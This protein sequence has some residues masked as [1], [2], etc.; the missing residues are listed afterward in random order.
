[1]KAKW[2]Y[3]FWGGMDLFYVGRFCYVNF[4][5]GRIPFYTDIQ[6]YALVGWGHGSIPGLFFLLDMALNISIIF[7]M[8][9]FFRGSRIAPYVAYAQAPFRLLLAIPS[10][11]F[12]IWFT[13]VGE[14]TSV[15]LLVSLL[16]VSELAKVFSIFFREKVS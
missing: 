1:M 7:S 11:S 16:L 13:K 15:I 4:S 3:L 9:L 12:L 6:T 14:V 8:F 2:L 5:N 10:L